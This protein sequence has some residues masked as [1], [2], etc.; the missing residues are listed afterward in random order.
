MNPR[1]TMILAVVVAAIAAYIFAVDRPQAQRAEQAK[2]LVQLRKSDITGVS[3]VTS[4][5]AVE[6]ARRDATHWDITRPY[7]TPAASFSV[8]DLLDAVTGIVPQRTLGGVGQDAAAYG[9]NAPDVKMTLR[10]TGGKTATVE[11]GKA[12]PVGTAIYARLDSGTVYLVDG[13]VKDSLSKSAADL[14]QK[15][16]ADFANADVQQ[17]RIASSDTTLVVDRTGP[18]RW[19][20]EGAGAPRA[21]PAWPA[22]DFKVTDLF[23]PLTTS[24]AKRFHDGVTD[25]GPYGLDHPA[26]AMDLTL[27]GRPEP[28]RILVAPG[29]KVAYGMVAGAHTVFELDPS[30]VGKVAPASIS[31]VS[32]RVLP[33]NPADLT[34]FTWRRNGQSLEIHRQGPG[35]TGGRLSDRDV[36]DMFSAMN[37]LDADSVRALTSPPQ[38]APAFEIRTDGGTDARFAVAFHAQPKGGWIVTDQALGLEYVVAA[39]ALDALP[40]SI[41]TFLGLPAQAGAPSSGG[42]G[43]AVTRPGA[44][45]PPPGT[46]HKP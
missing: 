12:S 25:L 17:V 37:L 10:A 19:R 31:L 14:R 11:L 41:K 9:L 33:Y 13:A 18:D 22:D 6:L 42:H 28:L 35:F 8:N 40:K 4:K 38:G 21:R 34:A 3:L 5:G 2:H 23:F 24:E 1:V 20:I 27:K 30:I 7:G 15:T 46:P 32:T 43:P 29:G 45:P 36:S 39:N 16:L 44:T 26:V